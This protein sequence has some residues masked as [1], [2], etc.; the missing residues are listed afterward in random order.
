MRPHTLRLVAFG[1]FAEEQV[2]DFDRLAEEGLFLIHGPTGSGKTTL[3]DAIVFAL[4]GTKSSD[5]IERFVSHH[6]DKGT[7][8]VV[9]LEF[10]VRN[11]RYR[12]ERSPSYL[13]PGRKKDSLSKVGQAATLVRQDNG[14]ETPLASGVKEVTDEITNLI[15]LS[16]EQFTQVM[17]LPQGRF[18]QVLKSKS[19]ERQ[20]LLETLFE[21]SLYGAIETWF[22]GEKTRAVEELED[23][24]TERDHLESDANDR[25]KDLKKHAPTVPVVELA[26]DQDAREWITS[27][28][29]AIRTES[30]KADAECSVAEDEFKKATETFSQARALHER[31]KRREEDT[32]T[33]T[34]LESQQPEI[35]ALKARLARVDAALELRPV[36]DNVEAA[37]ARSDTALAKLDQALNDLV[38]QMGNIASLDHSIETALDALASGTAQLDGPLASQIREGMKRARQRVE[39]LRN[40]TAELSSQES[41]LNG[42]SSAE[43]QL[44]KKHDALSKATEGLQQKISETEQRKSELQE[45]AKDL[46]ALEVQRDALTKRLEAAEKV[47][48]LSAQVQ[49]A[50]QSLQGLVDRHQGA[51]DAEQTLRTK[52][53]DGI[54]A[55]LAGSLKD[56]QPCPVCGS[57]HHPS[58]AVPADDAVTRSQ[59]DKAASESKKAESARAAAN[60]ELKSLEMELVAAQADA[61]HDST[62]ESLTIELDE[63]KASL[64][65]A[66][67]AARALEE[68]TEE[69][70]QHRQDLEE[71]RNA[72]HEVETELAVTTAK[73]TAVRKRVTELT[74][75]VDT[76]CT[77]GLQ[78]DQTDQ[79]LADLDGVEKS[80]ESARS[81]RAEVESAGEDLKKQRRVVEEAVQKS[82]FDDEDVVRT[83]LHEYDSADEKRDDWLQRINHHKNE[84]H[85]IRTF[86]ASPE[87]TDLP[88]TEPSV[89]EAQAAVETARQIHKEAHEY[90][91]ILRTGLSG[92]SEVA[93]KYAQLVDGSAELNRRADLLSHLSNRVNGK[94][95][96]KIPLRRWVLRTYLDEI[97]D[98]ANARLTAMTGGRYRLVVR[99]TEANANKQTGLDLNVFDAHTGEERDVA[100]L[101]GGETFQASLS[102]ALGVADA[103]S[104]HQGGI[105]LE[106]LFVD[107]GFGSLDQDSLQVAMDRLDELRAGG[108]MVGL[109]SHVA[110]LRERIGYGIEVTST[111][112]GSKARLG[113]V[114]S[115]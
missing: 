84:I 57:Q 104:A 33:L 37:H 99:T 83:V 49:A 112:K 40:T 5:P 45:I 107:E 15:G 32:R 74:E 65:A 50:T 95:A 1:A 21:T 97:C 12:V 55:E 25:V 85:R 59:V 14:H 115:V 48:E 56:G 51:V 62:T 110:A 75:T 113:E 63:L 47:T 26:D 19:E 28:V 7:K 105:H 87:A 16:R 8:P 27:T 101:S 17:L 71:S 52:Y 108:R 39:K 93:R 34:E 76:L 24:N 20:Q 4:F 41:Q 23:L 73:L 30:D 29:E 46:A 67:S 96:P 92:L 18:E 54:A 6:V 114:M 78:P 89:T 77:D 86:L 58:V 81:A 35:D 3:L 66:D 42:L 10:S 82:V 36:I 60:T 31:W 91:T 69:L 102:L 2:I 79:R 88:D 103:V 53:L 70:T 13:T 68:L 9:E 94:S 64:T 38:A 43:N 98:F 22:A 72:L 106:A 111:P 109:I 61:G 80:F 44:T 11:T 100:T 90:S